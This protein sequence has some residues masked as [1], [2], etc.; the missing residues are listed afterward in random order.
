MTFVTTK[1]VL[2]MPMS[3]MLKI[4]VVM[5]STA[6][7]VMKKTHISVIQKMAIVA[8]M[9]KIFSFLLPKRHKE[10]SQVH[11]FVKVCKEFA[12][13]I[14]VFIFFHSVFSATK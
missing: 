7:V 9:M 1:V 8:K 4:R 12:F 5:K 6:A 14:I 13:F 11:Y 2:K 3:L 10:T